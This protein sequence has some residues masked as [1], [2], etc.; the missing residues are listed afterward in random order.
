MIKGK[1][2]KIQ[3]LSPSV[4]AFWFFSPVLCLV[5]V[6]GKAVTSLDL[7]TGFGGQGIFYVSLTC[8]NVWRWQGWLFFL[9]FIASRVTWVSTSNSVLPEL[10]ILV[11]PCAPFLFS[12][13]GHRQH[14]APLYFP[15]ANG[16]PPCLPT[17]PAIRW[18]LSTH[19]QHSCQ[20]ASSTSLSISSGF[21]EM[22]DSLWRWDRNGLSSP[23]PEYPIC[24]ICH[25]APTWEETMLNCSPSRTLFTLEWKP[26]YLRKLIS[27]AIDNGIINFEWKFFTGYCITLVCRLKGLL[28]S[29]QFKFTRP[30]C[31]ECL[32]FLAIHQSAL[33]WEG[34]AAFR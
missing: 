15:L 23:T 13:A 27:S 11:L 20:L 2:G 26:L 18:F 33:Q 22:K 3:A 10:V 21:S 28:C 32:C 31:S 7:L 17:L 14:S 16:Q 12:P 25:F 29:I 24:R 19:F 8:H 6:P 9:R 34:A 5:F 4:K 30:I 1:P